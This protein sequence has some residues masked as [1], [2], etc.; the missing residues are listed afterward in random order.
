MTKEKTAFEMREE[1]EHQEALKKE[2]QEEK[3]LNTKDPDKK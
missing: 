3:D 1:E 2:I